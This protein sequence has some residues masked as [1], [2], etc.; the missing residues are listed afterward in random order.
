RAREPLH[1]E[2]APERVLEIGATAGAT[3][4]DRERVRSEARDRARRAGGVARRRALLDRGGVRVVEEPAEHAALDDRVLPAALAVAVEGSRARELAVEGIVVDVERRR[5]DRLPELARE[6]AAPALDRDRARRGDE[7]RD[8]ELEE[9]VGSEQDR[10][11][12]RLGRPRA[13]VA[14]DD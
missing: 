3:R 11:R 14:E 13:Q 7:R 8:E 6:R 12:V 10:A 1:E 4:R 2:A 9:G 5:R